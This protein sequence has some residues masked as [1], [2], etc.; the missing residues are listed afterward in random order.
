MDS[1]FE[2]LVVFLKKLFQSKKLYR[3]LNWI[4][5]SSQAIKHNFAL[6]QQH[7]PHYAI[8][9]VLKS[10]AYGHGI[11]QV[12]SIMN[13][14]KEC[15]LIAVDSY[16]EYQIIHKNSTKNILIMGETWLENYS[17]FDSKR[18]HFAV[19]SLDVISI[20]WGLKR[21]FNVHI[22]INSGMNRE[23]IK[24]WVDLE[25]CIE[26]IQQYKNIR[27]VWIMSHLACADD[28]KHELNTIQSDVFYNAVTY[29]RE[30]WIYPEYI[31]LEASAGMINNIDSHKICTAGRLWLWLYGLDPLYANEKLSQF[32]E[33]L[34]AALNVYST[35][36][37]I[38]KLQKEDTVGYSWTRKSPEKL[39]I[40]TF[41]FGYREGLDRGLSWK[42]WKVR[43]WEWFHE[44]IWRISMNY[45]WSL[46]NN[47]ITIGDTVHIISSNTKDLNSIYRFYDAI[48]KISYEV[49][50]LDDKIKRITI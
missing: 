12:A 2:Q 15:T 46:W 4:T 33:K 42:W 27:I 3:S 41:P 36:T 35:I 43:I 48:G 34:L 21:C 32:G 47:T 6:F 9:P 40:S 31:H 22:F 5:I 10:N 1:M 30:Q 49:V 14:I 20:L 16:P 44:I 29:I 38:Q 45:A 24:P 18:T 28:S 17:L 11:K 37:C 23:W 7:K 8:I 39:T 19:R 26:T 50:K 13:T 25:K